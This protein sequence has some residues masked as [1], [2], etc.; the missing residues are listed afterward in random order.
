MWSSITSVAHSAV[1]LNLWFN[2]RFNHV[3]GVNYFNNYI[4]TD[5]EQ[6]LQNHQYVEYEHVI[7]THHLLQKVANRKSIFRQRRATFV[8]SDCSLGNY[9]RRLVTLISHLV[10]R[11]VPSQIE[12]GYVEMGKPEITF[13]F[14][15][16]W[17]E[18]KHAP[19]CSNPASLRRETRP[20]RLTDMEVSADEGSSS[21][22]WW[23]TLQDHST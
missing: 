2:P 17:S 18:L 5:W 16:C 3:R 4:R 20:W 12:S 23:C 11:E 8:L 22:T 15:L 14:C 1:H 21:A 6:I 13:K 19:V 10:K 9:I 7:P